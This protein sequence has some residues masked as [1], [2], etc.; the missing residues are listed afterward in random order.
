MQTLID[1]LLQEDVADIL[2]I[3]NHVYQIDTQFLDVGDLVT[4]GCSRD[5]A[6]FLAQDDDLSEPLHVSP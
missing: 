4:V 2:D 1:Y 5:Q 3:I 6:A